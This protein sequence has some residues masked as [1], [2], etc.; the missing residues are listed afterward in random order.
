MVNPAINSNGN[1]VKPIAP[2]RNLCERKIGIEIDVFPHA[3]WSNFKSPKFNYL[4][5]VIKRNASSGNRQDCPRYRIVA[6]QIVPPFDFD[7][8]PTWLYGLK[9]INYKGK[10]SV[11]EIDWY[12]EDEICASSEETLLGDIEF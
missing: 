5:D 3:D 1:T 8:P 12:G 7:E 4:Q 11:R 2:Q 9:P 10:L 6:A